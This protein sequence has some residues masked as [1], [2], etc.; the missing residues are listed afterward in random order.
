MI[1]NY[2]LLDSDIYSYYPAP[3]FWIRLKRGRE[4]WRKIW[5][6]I[7]GIQFRFWRFGGSI[8]IGSG[9]YGG[10]MSRRYITLGLTYWIEKLSLYRPWWRYISRCNVLPIKWV[11]FWYTPYDDYLENGGF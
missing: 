1:T 10:L 4:P 5:S 6:N 3:K 11:L 7:N 9:K 2:R 8:H